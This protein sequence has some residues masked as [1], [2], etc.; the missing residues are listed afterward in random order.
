MIDRLLELARNALRGSARDK[1]KCRVLFVCMANLCRSP[2]A[3]AVFREQ[4]RRSAL[5][6]LIYCDSAG[7]HDFNS[8]AK[9]DGRA[10]AA[11]EKR[12]YSM[13]GQRGRPVNAE[14][15]VAF[16][17][18]LALDQQVLENLTERCPNQYRQRIQPLM[19]YARRHQS[20]DV[21]DPYYS[22]AQGFEL[23]L[24]MI[25]DACFELLAHVREKHL[26]LA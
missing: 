13:K 15:F 18:I 5:S 22:N 7:T 26:N 6:E 17:L 12:G 19:Q 9:P 1:A 10:R 23:V 25:E 3:Q 4:V 24:D 2:M 14:D 20:L 16:D 11:V 8:R 21:P